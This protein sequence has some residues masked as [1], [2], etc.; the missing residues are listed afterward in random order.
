MPLPGYSRQ[1][2]LGILADEVLPCLI[3]EE[4]TNGEAEGQEDMLDRHTLDPVSLDLA[5]RL[6]RR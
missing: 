5:L 6:I 4:D 3:E 1:E 2:A